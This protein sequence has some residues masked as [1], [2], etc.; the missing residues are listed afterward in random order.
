MINERVLSYTITKRNLKSVFMLKPVS[1]N[2][3]VTGL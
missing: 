2:Q 1:R 3:R